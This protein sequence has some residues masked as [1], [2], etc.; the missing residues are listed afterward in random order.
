MATVTI[1]RTKKGR[2]IT[3]KAGK[4]EDLRNVLFALAGE[5]PPAKEYCCPECSSNDPN[6]YVRCQWAGCPDGRDPR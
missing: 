5:K 4:G 6:K 1:K 2:T 3:M